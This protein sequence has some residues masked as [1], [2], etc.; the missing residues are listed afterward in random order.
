MT[1][2]LR[3]YGLLAVAVAALTGCVAENAGYND[4]KRLTA[5]RLEVEASWKS[6]EQAAPREEVAELVKQPLT[7]ELAGKIAVLNSPRI[8]AEFEKL[9]VAR[10][11]WV[12]ALQ[13]PNP[14]VGGALVYGIDDSPELDLDAAINVTAL[15]LLPSRSGIADV[16]LQA[17]V[18]E[19][20]NTVLE[21]AFDAKRAF[22]EFQ[23]SS[24]EL[25]LRKTITQSWFA[26]SEMAKRLFEL[27]NV[28]ELRSAN[29]RAFY[30]ETRVQQARTEARVQAA[31]EQLN[32]VL[33]LWG[34][35]GARWEQA[36]GPLPSPE[37][38]EE[39]RAL[40]VG[41]EAQAIERSLGLEAARLRYQA[42]AKQANL[43]R[44]A[45]WTPQ[46]HAG[47][48]VARERDDG[49]PARW[50]AG[51]LVE[52]GVPLFYQGQGESGVALAE[53]RR[54]VNLLDDIAIR[55]RS[56]SR[57]AQAKLTVA[58]Q[59]AAHY[60]DVI[61]PLR[62]Q[63]VEQTQLQYNAMNVG[64]F[65]LLQAKNMEIA[66]HLA[67]LEVVRDYW[68][69]RLDIEQLRKGGLRSG[70]VSVSLSPTTVGGASMI[71]PAHD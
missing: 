27:G 22:I 44:F 61:L 12:S 24:A 23:I 46:I 39:T 35:W 32:A 13:L 45:G 68:L 1:L 38:L 67:Y 37:P 19:V 51:P 7:A 20:V 57:A 17:T 21:V 66:A 58:A 40:L 42:L 62:G 52:L 31:R 5:A 55:T 4:V 9:G 16:Q 60:R 56:N 49:E 41:L 8:Q 59:T 15:A 26:S 50:G 25:E 10:A 34:E 11:A 30:E 48:R 33:G 28:P 18:R 36:S 53:M 14:T 64:V 69:T 2:R 65:E 3:H 43:A 70:A 54:Q 6:K 71:A 47:V 63:V 29:E